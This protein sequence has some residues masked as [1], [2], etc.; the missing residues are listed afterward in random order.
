MYNKFASWIGSWP[1]PVKH[2]LAVFIG[3]LATVISGAII[4]HGG[5]WGLAWLDVF[6]D[7]TDKGVVAAL[8]TIGVFTLTPLTSAYGIGKVVDSASTSIDVAAAPEPLVDYTGIPVPLPNDA[9]TVSP[10]SLGGINAADDALLSDSVVV[11][12]PAL[13]DGVTG[14]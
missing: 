5:V 10:N 8:A 1:T 12:D 3:T 13:Q 6:K 7:G 9:S 4:A 11:S 14:P 2:F